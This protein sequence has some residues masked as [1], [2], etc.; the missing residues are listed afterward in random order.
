METSK[1]FL[2]IPLELGKRQVKD[3]LCMTCLLGNIRINHVS[4]KGLILT[5]LTVDLVFIIV[6]FAVL[7]YG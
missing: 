3:T 1:V 7:L 5:S 4:T 6:K 2:Q